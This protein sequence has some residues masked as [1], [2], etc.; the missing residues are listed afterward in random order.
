MRYGKRPVAW[1][2]NSL[3]KRTASFWSRY[4]TNIEQRK[5]R[6]KAAS[7]NDS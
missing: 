6:Q 5:S 4:M 3:T 1:L 7:G 2:L